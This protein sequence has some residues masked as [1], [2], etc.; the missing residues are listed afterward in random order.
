MA[1]AVRD[2]VL[3]EAP[4]ELDEGETTDTLDRRRRCVFCVFWPLW[5]CEG[6]ALGLVMSAFEKACEGVDD[7]IPKQAVD[8]AWD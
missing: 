1:D 2:G 6:V 3:L 8:H 7:A 5:V 4:V